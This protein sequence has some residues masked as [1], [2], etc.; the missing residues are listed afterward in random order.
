MHLHLIH[1]A[2]TTHTTTT[3]T[4]TTITTTPA[5][6]PRCHVDKLSTNFMENGFILECLIKHFSDLHKPCWSLISLFDPAEAQRVQELEKSHWDP[7][8][9]EAQLTKV[10]SWSSAGV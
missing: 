2:P 7:K 3:T 10:R 6:P 8:L 5:P 9:V 1:V 4:T